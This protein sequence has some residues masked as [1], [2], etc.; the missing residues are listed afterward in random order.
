M[1]EEYWAGSQLSV[2]R[3]YGA[4]TL[5]GQE[6]QIVNKKGITLRELS[7]P[8]SRHYVKE[9]M[10]IP[11][12]EPADLIDTDFIGYYKKLGRERFM[13]ILKDH[14]RTERTALLAIYKDATKEKE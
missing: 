5:N 10:A 3:I 2:A 1:T 4:I 13:E 14:Q 6:F 11:P 7:N 12:G 8:K 9:G